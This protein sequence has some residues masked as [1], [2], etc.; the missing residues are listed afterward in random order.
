VLAD[1]E[2]RILNSDGTPTFGRVRELFPARLPDLFEGDQ[3]VLLGQYVGSAPLT[4]ELGGNFRG[5]PRQFRFS[6]DLDRAST[7]N[8][9]VPRLWA[10]RK[11]AM[12]ID[13]IRQLGAD[14]PGAPGTLPDLATNDPRL[15]E[16][17]NEVVRLSTEFGILTEYTAFLAR[18]GTDLSQP[19]YVQREATRNFSGR[20]MAIRSGL[21]SA[22]QTINIAGQKKQQVLNR[23]NEFFD[24]QMNAVQVTTV[25]QVADRAFYRRGQRWIDSRIVN[26]AKSSTPDRTIEFGSD[27]FWDLLRRLVREDRAGCVALTGDIVLQVGG[28]TVLIQSSAA[29]PMQSQP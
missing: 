19:E 7:R 1:T 2:L 5:R 15:R 13:A 17:I 16:L 12:L 20:A 26:T 3:L 24:A 6:F 23:R 27:A 25:Q 9:F 14:M 29:S 21:A 10:S 28:E 8:A 18:E 11:I 4:F 22:N